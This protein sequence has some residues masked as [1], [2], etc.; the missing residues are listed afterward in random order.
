MI[1]NIKMRRK[2]WLKREYVRRLSMILKTELRTKNKKQAIGLLAVPLLRYIF[3]I[4]NC[5]Q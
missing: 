1:L 4:V 3:R 2:S 5:N